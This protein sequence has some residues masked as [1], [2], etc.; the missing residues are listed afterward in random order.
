M[1]KKSLKHLMQQFGAAY[2][3]GLV[4]GYIID[5]YTDTLRIQFFP[6]TNIPRHTLAE[7]IKHTYGLT[8]DAVV[9]KNS[10]TRTEL[11]VH[12]PQILQYTPLG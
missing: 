11:H 7:H 5:E 8:E 3:H 9:W 12:I 10:P 1:N 2:T 6:R 4:L